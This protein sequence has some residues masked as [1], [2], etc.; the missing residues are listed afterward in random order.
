[1][2]LLFYVERA[3]RRKGLAYEALQLFLSYTTR[4]NQEPPGLALSPYQLVV[5]IGGSNIASRELFKRLGFVIS[6]EVVV[7]NEVE[8]RWCW[9]GQGPQPE[10]FEER[11]LSLWGDGGAIVHY[12]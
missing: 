2:R 8:M 11:I 6:K 4:R 7:F 10:R 12:P 1:M 3:Y 5:R 9:D